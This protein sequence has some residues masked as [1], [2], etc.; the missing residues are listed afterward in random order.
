VR[1]GIFLEGPI[2]HSGSGPTLNFGL[3]LHLY[4]QPALH[5]LES[6]PILHSIIRTILHLQNVLYLQQM[7]CPKACW[8]TCIIASPRSSSARSNVASMSS[9]E[10]P[11]YGPSSRLP[12]RDIV[13]G[14]SGDAGTHPNSNDP[15]SRRALG[16]KLPTVCLLVCQGPALVD[17][18]GGAFHLHIAQPSLSY[19]CVF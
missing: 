3:I 7:I 10:L 4:F 1:C 18:L 19:G 17:A 11:P 8:R 16:S 12:P 6:G 14:D 9:E 2:L 5:L 15:C 13:V